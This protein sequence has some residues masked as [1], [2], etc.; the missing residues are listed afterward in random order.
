MNATETIIAR[1]SGKDT[2]QPGEIVEVEVDFCMAN[3]VTIPLT[4]DIF[5]NEFGFSRVF[6]PAKIVFVHDHRIPADC[7]DTALGH[8]KGRQFASKH[9]FKIHENDGI[10]HQLMFEQYIKP[11]DL[12]V[13]ADSHTCSYG[14]VGVVSTGMGSTDIAAVL[15]SG[16]TWLKVPETIGIEITGS[17]KPGVYAKDVILHIIKTISASGASYQT[18]EFFGETIAHM[19]VSER[20]TLCN[21]VIE[22]GGKS[23][24][25]KPDAKVS[26]WFGN[27]S[28][29]LALFSDTQLGANSERLCFNISDLNPQVAC[30]HKVDNV[31]D[32]NRVENRKIDQAFLGACTNGRLD[33]LRIAAQMLKGKKVH[34]AVRFLVTPASVNIYLEALREGLLETLIKAGVI[35]NHPG[36]GTCWGA[37]QGVLAKGQTMI[38]TANR[39]FKGRA[40]AP[41][42]EIYLASPATVTAS[43]IAG[44]IAHPLTYW[45]N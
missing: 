40:G 34:P 43:A 16:K 5:E 1:H 29:S 7:V 10:C 18:I 9:G 22:A 19:S 17:L 2:V 33:D 38:S 15:G 24:M 37:C 35:I 27:H 13:A 14:C 30:P 26:K 20:F 44:C 8:S 42:S 32:I 6:D 23:A 12:V 3:D 41:D 28:L 25:I 21:M 36:C 31:V 4:V 11:G 39:N 45:E